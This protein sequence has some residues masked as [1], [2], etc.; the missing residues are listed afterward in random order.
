MLRVAATAPAFAAWRQLR[1]SSGT[2]ATV[3]SDGTPGRSRSVTCAGSRRNGS[4]LACATRG[5][6]PGLRPAPGR[7][8]PH[9]HG[10]DRLSAS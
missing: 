8:P 4:R 3:R 9:R 2:I 5:F 1:S 6:G 10:T 7:R